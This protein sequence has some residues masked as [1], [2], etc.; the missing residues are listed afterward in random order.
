MGTPLAFK[1]FGHLTKYWVEVP[2]S[3]RVI[4]W[5][6]SEMLIRY[7]SLGQSGGH[8]RRQTDILRAMLL[9]Y[10]ACDIIFGLLLLWFA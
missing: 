10:K 7:L 1:V 3:L 6:P 2:K 9:A 8:T 5:E 4:F